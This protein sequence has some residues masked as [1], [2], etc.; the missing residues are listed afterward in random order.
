[1]NSDNIKNAEIC[2][3]KNIE[4]EKIGNFFGKLDNLITLHQRQENLVKNIAKTV[5]KCMYT[6]RRRN[7]I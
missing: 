5:V 4:Q 1:M 6:E 3:P 2:L 7:D